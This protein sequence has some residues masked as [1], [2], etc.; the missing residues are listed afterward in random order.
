MILK[1][2][3]GGKAGGRPDKVRNRSLTPFAPDRRRTRTFAPPITRCRHAAYTENR[4]RMKRRRRATML[5][6]H[7]HDT[8]DETE[9]PND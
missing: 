5:R 1:Q 2:M 4:L 7:D 3:T 6:R 8:H 9:S